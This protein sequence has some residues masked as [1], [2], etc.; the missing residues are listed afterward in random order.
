L[1]FV[2]L[3]SFPP[4]GLAKHCFEFCFMLLGVG[5]R[6]V[7]GNDNKNFRAENE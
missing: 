2:Y 1:L 3:G 7:W 5:G 4:Y 6:D